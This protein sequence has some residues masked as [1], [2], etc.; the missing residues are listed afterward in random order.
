MKI[1]ELNVDSL[2]Q[3]YPVIKQL[4]PHLGLDEF[5]KMATTMMQDGYRAI[6]VYDGDEIVAYAGFAEL[7]NLYDGRHIY[8]Y[9]LIV[10]ENHRS[11]GYGK[12][13]MSFIEDIAKTKG[14]NRVTLISGVQR[15][16]AHRFYED[17]NGYV[18]TSYSYKKEV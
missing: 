5:V 14:V 7:L 12:M 11:R 9:D 13:L 6:C 3:A 10:C 2:F 18:K 16:D 4:R 15:K 17:K 8:V 1:K